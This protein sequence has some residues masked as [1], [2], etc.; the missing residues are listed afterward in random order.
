MKQ[1]NVLLAGLLWLMVL[2]TVSLVSAQGGSGEAEANGGDD[3]AASSPP[4]QEYGGLTCPVGVPTEF[5][6]SDFET[7][8]GGWTATG[9][10]NFWEYGP[11][12]PGIYEICDTA[13]RPEPTGAFSGLNV[14][15]TNL[16]GCYPN[17]NTDGILS[18]TFD[19]STLSAPIELSWYHWYEVF[20]TFDYA[21]AR[22]N[23]TQ[24]WRTP[25]STPTANYIY[26]P[27]DLSAY[28]GNASVT[29]DFLLHAT[30]VV[31][32]MGWYVD[33]VAIRYCDTSGGTP[34]PTAT[35]TATSTALPT[36]TAT[37]TSTALPTATAT[38]TALPTATAT[39]TVEPTASSTPPPTDVQLSSFSGSTN[40]Y[41]GLGVLWV[42]TIFGLLILARRHRTDDTA[43]DD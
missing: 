27:I 14:W 1:K 24:V 2:L 16:N 3:A 34:T 21:I 43:G 35:A 25:N 15:G 9:P 20:E 11:V 28:A 41:G 33:D 10:A 5:Y 26:Q 40:Q 22:V 37:A 31:N 13:P 12:V 32:R 17:A 36:A 30:T 39:A 42:L 29:I 23:G 18:R 6:F 4:A 7:N 19:L 38:S 8:N